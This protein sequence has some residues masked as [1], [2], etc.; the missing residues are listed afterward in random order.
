MAKPPGPTVLKSFGRQKYATLDEISEREAIILFIGHYSVSFLAKRIETP[1]PLWL[2][3]LAVQFIDMIWALFIFTGV[4]KANISHEVPGTPLNLFFMPYSHSLI[5]ALFWSGVAFTIVRYLP[6]INNRNFKKAMIVS[7]AV[8]SH[9]ILD[10][11]VHT[12]DLPLW[13]NE[14]K[15]GLG[16]YEYAYISFFLELFFLILGLVLYIGLTTGKGMLGTLGIYVLLI[17][18][19]LLGINS[20]WGV[21]PPNTKI[22]AGFL[23]FSYIFFSLIIAWL[24][25]KRILKI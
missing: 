21:A 10:L 18:I 24:E 16:L 22:A 7:I 17:L 12:G 3:F 8:F 23:L 13:L 9:W 2:L 1:L 14:F 25:K 11:I 20:V 19:V 6:I 15:V 5:G 4:E